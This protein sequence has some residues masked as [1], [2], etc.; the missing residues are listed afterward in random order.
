M[1][2][3]FLNRA[4]A[5]CLVAL[6]LASVASAKNA[7]T[8]P[9]AATAFEQS[10]IG[11]EKNFIAAA[12]TG[13]AAFLKRT[14]SDDFSNV[15]IDGQLHDRQEVIDEL[16]EGG[17]EITPY[18]FKVVAAGDDTAIVTYDA[19]VQTPPEEDQG[20]PPRYQHF[21]SV[22]VKHAGEWK[23]TFQQ[24]TPTHWGDW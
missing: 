7:T 10:L 9:K 4:V 23:L 2:H 3:F 11:A 16:S 19:V 14:L 5:P 12:K 22:W 1:K 20:P 6:S 21:S 13:D 17:T 18:T 15:E 24:T 8:P